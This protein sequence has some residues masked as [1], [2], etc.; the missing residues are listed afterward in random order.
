MQLKEQIKELLIK[1]DFDGLKNLLTENDIDSWSED[2][3]D[4]VYD[5]KNLLAYTFVCMTLMKK[6][7]SRLHCLAAALL[8]HSLCYINGAYAS[9]LYHVRK[10]IELDPNDVGLKESLLFFHV[11]PDQL[12]SRDEAVQIALEVLKNDHQ[13]IAARDIIERHKKK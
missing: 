13:S 10:A 11:I 1:N 2:L 4:V 6:E 3:V 5:T 7:S 9:A 8:S 12:L